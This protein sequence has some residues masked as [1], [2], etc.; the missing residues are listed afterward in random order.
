[1]VELLIAIIII[2]ILVTIIVPVISNRASDARITAAKADLEAIANAQS[3]VAIDTGYV[4]R[5][6]VLDDSGAVGDNLGSDDPNDVIDTIRDEEFNNA[7]APERI[8]LDVKTG[9]LMP[10]ILYQR[11]KLDPEAFGWRGPYVNFQRKIPAVPAP[12]TPWTA[13]SPLDP[14]GNPYFLFVPGVE[15]VGGGTP[16]VGGWLN[17]MNAAGGPQT[18][19]SYAGSSAIATQF[20]RMTVLSLGPNG[21]PGDGSGIDPGPGSLGSGDDLY[22]AF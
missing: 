19:F 13:G 16:A 8:F 3:Q 14:W 11:V 1:M 21:L 20:D 15:P 18:T 17:E 7:D 10:Q 22:R 5:L 6:H 2:G 12:L 4:V 9:E